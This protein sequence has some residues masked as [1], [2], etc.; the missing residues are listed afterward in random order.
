M[1]PLHPENLD[2]KELPRLSEF[3]PIAFFTNTA[4]MDTKTVLLGHL[5]DAKHPTLK[6]VLG[7]FLIVVRVPSTTSSSDVVLV[8]LYHIQCSCL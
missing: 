5:E 2:V 8:M 6:G 4:N 3:T 7:G 1:S